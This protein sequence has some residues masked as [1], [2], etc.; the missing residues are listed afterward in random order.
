VPVFLLLAGALALFYPGL[1]TSPAVLALAVA[2]MF[3]GWLMALYSLLRV[4]RA[5][6][7]RGTHERILNA[8]LAAGAAGIGVYLLGMLK[9]DAFFFN[10]ARELGLWCRCCSASATA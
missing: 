2:L 6:R 1:F 4:Y 5:A 8:A 9:G 3:A 10:L 7:N